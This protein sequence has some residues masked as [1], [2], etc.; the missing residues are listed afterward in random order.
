V[1]F[2]PKIDHDAAV[3]LQYQDLRRTRG[4]EVSS[5]SKAGFERQEEAFPEWVPTTPLHG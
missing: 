3:P 5:G 4:H 2:N 1:V